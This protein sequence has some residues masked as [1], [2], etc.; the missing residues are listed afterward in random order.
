MSALRNFTRSSRKPVWIIVDKVDSF[1]D[2]PI[3]LPK[4]KDIG[5]FKWIMAG[6]AGIGTWVAQNSLE[7]FVFDLEKRVL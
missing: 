1:Q 4:D 2:F 3:C 7:N 6:S 5:P